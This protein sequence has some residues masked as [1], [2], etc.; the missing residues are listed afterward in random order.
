MGEEKV[1]EQSPAEP[2]KWSRGLLMIP[3]IAGV[4]IAGAAFGLPLVFIRKKEQEPQQNPETPAP[5]DEATD[6]FHLFKT[7]HAGNPD[8]REAPALVTETVGKSDT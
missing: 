8:D 2:K 5:V 6:Q 7:V 1:P 3:I 4:V